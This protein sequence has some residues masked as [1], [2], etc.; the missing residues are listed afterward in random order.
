MY[1][2]IHAQYQ[3]FLP[4]FDKIWTDKIWT[5]KTWIFSA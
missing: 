4:D 3:L 1:I 2:D 5:D